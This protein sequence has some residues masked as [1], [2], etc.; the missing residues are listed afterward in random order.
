MNTVARLDRGYSLSDCISM[1]AMRERGL[2]EVLNND[3]HFRQ[4]GFV[5][6][7]DHT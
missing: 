7:C 1:N 4:E 6:L 5:V 3:A 2:F